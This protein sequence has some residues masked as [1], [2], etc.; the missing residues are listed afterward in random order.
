MR[1]RTG[2]A[3]TAVTLLLSAHLLAQQT[4]DKPAQVPKRIVAGL[5]NKETP[6]NR[7]QALEE[8]RVMPNRVLRF[9]DSEPKIRT[10]I[11]LADALWGKSTDE[12]EARLLFLKADELIR[13][14][15]ISKENEPPIRQEKDR[16]VASV[17]PS[18]LRSLKSLL[19]QRATLHDATL[20]QRLSREYGLSDITNQDSFAV[21]ALITQGQT[22]SATKS[23][24]NW[25][26]DDLSGRQ[27]LHGFLKLLLQL[28]A[29]DAQAADG[30]FTEATVRMSGQPNVTANDVLIMG[31]YLFASRFMSASL[32][33]ETRIFGTTK[34]QL[35]DVL[36]E[37]DVAQVRPGNSAAAIGAYL[38]AATQL[39]GRG[40]YDPEETKRRA[41]AA[42]LLLP[43]AQAFAPEFVPQLLAIQRGPGL[44]F[45]LRRPDPLPLTENGKVDQKALLEAVDAITTSK[46]RDQYILT[47]VR[48]LYLKG[49][50]D[51]A[52]A[53]AEKAEDLNV[54]NQLVGVVTFAR[55]AK[56]L[57]EGQ[58]EITEKS[59]NRVTSTLQRFLLRLGMARLYLKQ[60][61]EPAAGALVNVA[62]KDV[63]DHGD[64]IE[65]PYLILA[66]VQLL[67][68]FDLPVATDGLREAIKAFN[69]L[70]PPRKARAG[71]SLLETI[72]VGD[73]STTF[74]LRISLVK[75]ESLGATLKSF[76]S[77]PQGVRV[78][79]FELKDE[80][81]LSEAMIAFA[82]TLLR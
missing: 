18:V 9:Q 21:S 12:T 51:A 31:N 16:D 17:S 73:S 35:G 65:K 69:A 76:S 19:V 4:V 63:R 75:F 78:I 77:D 64:D 82:Y 27:A 44:D 28:R 81:I 2:L 34:I 41:A 46:L 74:P 56:S 48:K 39:L 37:A 52:Q 38:G 3:V 40:S 49:D 13:A 11:G 72:K 26:N 67:A 45:S 10:I 30:L 43:H 33:K 22:A 55:A 36:V 80:R 24:Q 71:A 54:R 23:L 59:L 15:R 32:L 53:V 58:V 47:A 62:I 1:I 8:V 7:K 5:E 60:R 6:A 50:L 29:Q 20:G 66:A 61:D 25:I 42:Y 57:E 79:L 70:E 68:S 14:V